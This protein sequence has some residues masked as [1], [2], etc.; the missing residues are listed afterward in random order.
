[1]KALFQ[2]HT[3]NSA[4]GGARRKHLLYCNQFT[5]EGNC[6]FVEVAVNMGNPDP[7]TFTPFFHDP[8]SDDP[9]ELITKAELDIRRENATAN[10][11]NYDTKLRAG[12]VWVIEWSSEARQT[13]ALCDQMIAKFRALIALEVFSLPVTA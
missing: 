1:M 5:S 9:K 13:A 3:A 10:G 12:G 8:A 7:Y 11:D 2:I 4:V 6:A